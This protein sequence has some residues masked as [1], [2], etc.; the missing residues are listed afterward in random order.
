MLCTLQ[1]TVKVFEMLPQTV[2]TFGGRTFVIE[3]VSRMNEI[4]FTVIL[5]SQEEIPWID[6]K[7]QLPLSSVLPY[8]ML[9][10]V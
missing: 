3:K 9:P 8:I 2:Q 5:S 4:Y 1:F 7:M 10:N 6:L